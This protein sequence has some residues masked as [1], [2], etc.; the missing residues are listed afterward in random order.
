MGERRRAAWYGLKRPRLQLEPSSPQH[1][2]T[3]DWMLRMEAAGDNEAEEPR[4]VVL[5]DWYFY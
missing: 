5:A 1:V 2:P 3:R 4:G